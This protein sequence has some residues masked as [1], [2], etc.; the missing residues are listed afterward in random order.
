MERIDTAKGRGELTPRREPYWSKI[1]NGQ[2]LGY[3]KSEEGGAW[4]ARAYDPG[5]RSRAYRALGDLSGVAPGDQ[6]DAA[7]RLAREWFTHIEQ[8][9]STDARTVGDACDRYVEHIRQTK[10][11]KA[12]GVAAQRLAALVTPDPIARI[13]LAKLQERH[14][15][16]WRR[17]LEQ[18]PCKAPA[19]GKNCR[20]KAPPPEPRRRTPATMNRD[21]TYLRAALNLAKADR[22]LVTDM[23]WSRALLPIKNA[24]RRRDTYLTREQRRALLDAI[25]CA[26][27]RALVAC[28]CAL[29]LRPGAVAALTVG[30]FDVRAGTLRIGVDKAGQGRKLLLPE[31]AIE[32]LRLQA[33]G[34]LPR[35]PLLSRPDGAAWDKD[36]WKKP[37]KAAVI[38]AG[39]P[40]DAVLY[41]LRHSAI[42][43]LVSSGLDLM[44]IAQIAGT[45]V[46][47][48][49][50]HYAHLQQDRARD[51][52]AGLAL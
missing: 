3:R 18:T 51:A 20:S 50:R 17:R 42:T 7:V 4:I 43:D 31:T 10:G 2:H 25:Q 8:G 48:V 1:G 12:A 27:L 34:K 46:R 30:D 6:Y 39:L 32:L 47:M 26:S 49:E 16:D 24:E 38:A 22:L 37:V 28:L 9:G 23:A 36:T 5:T 45:S 52:L 11:A 19:R 35:A 40:S 21:M 44:T 15:K 41:S 33:K 29:P 13:E 14:V